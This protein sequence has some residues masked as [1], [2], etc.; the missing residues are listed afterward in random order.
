MP[1]LAV[2]VIVLIAVAFVALAIRVDGVTLFGP[3]RTRQ[4]RGAAQTYCFG[5]CR[6]SSPDFCPLGLDGR[7]CPLWRFVD[8]DGPTQLPFSRERGMPLRPARG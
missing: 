4:L 8:E 5:K 2:I 3:G 6:R 7:T 1:A